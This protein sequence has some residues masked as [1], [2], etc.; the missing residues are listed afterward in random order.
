MTRMGQQFPHRHVSAFVKGSR[1][2]SISP[3]VEVS[4]AGRR[5]NP[6]SSDVRVCSRRPSTTICNEY[7]EALDEP[8]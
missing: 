1:P 4:G 7:F 6:R 3:P 2:T 8:P 5:R